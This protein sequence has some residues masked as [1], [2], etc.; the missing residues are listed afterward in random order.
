MPTSDL[1]KPAHPSYGLAEETRQRVLADAALVGV[2]KAAQL[3][4]L[5]ETAIY[6]WRKRSS[7]ASTI[8][9]AKDASE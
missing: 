2:A 7:L 6:N 9:P 5:S 1:T 8:T 4:R 3:H